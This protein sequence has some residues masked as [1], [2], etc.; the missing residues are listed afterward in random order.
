MT[1]AILWDVKQVCFI[2]NKEDIHVLWRMLAHDGN[3]LFKTQ[4][5]TKPNILFTVLD[6]LWKLIVHNFGIVKALIK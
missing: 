3:F 6:Q 4:A 2:P 5:T 1:V